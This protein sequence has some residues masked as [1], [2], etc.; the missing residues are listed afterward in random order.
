MITL[1]E[2]YHSKF[3][4]IKSNNI[5]HIAKRNTF[6]ESYGIAGKAFKIHYI[7][8]LN[9]NKKKKKKKEAKIELLQILKIISQNRL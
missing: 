2:D 7:I 6:N 4:N 5:F 1:T 8:C 9:S 3:R